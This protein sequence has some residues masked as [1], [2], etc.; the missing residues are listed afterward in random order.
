[1]LKVESAA[2]AI[3]RLNPGIEVI[4]HN[5]RLTGA[6]AQALI[7]PYDLVADGSDSIETRLAVHDACLAVGR[8]LVSASVQGM[9][10]QLTTY[11]AHL[12]PPHPCLRC[13]L[14]ETPDARALPSCAQAGVLGPAAGVVG[15]MQAVEVVKEIME[16]GRSLSGELLLYDAMDAA[17]DRFRLRRRP[18]CHAGCIHGRGQPAAAIAAVPGRIK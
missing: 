18:A 11:K 8:T 6:N 14:P 10:G 16:I 4:C 17:I 9:N 1:M 13:L 12:G 7:E 5:V 15:T 2:A 3:H